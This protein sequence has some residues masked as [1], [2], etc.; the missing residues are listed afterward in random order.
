MNKMGRA[1]NKQPS[2]MLST[3]KL[4]KIAVVSTTSGV[5]ESSYTLYEQKWKKFKAICLDANCRNG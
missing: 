3:T 2:E 1:Q 4:G 5:K